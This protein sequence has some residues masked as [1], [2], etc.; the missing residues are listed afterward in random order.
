MRIEGGACAPPRSSPARM[1]RGPGRPRFCPRRRLPEARLLRVSPLSS[2]RRSRQ[3]RPPWPR[4]AARPRWSRSSGAGMPPLPP[5]AR[6][7]P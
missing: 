2:S 4:P 6:A 3:R 1:S 7:P 5:R